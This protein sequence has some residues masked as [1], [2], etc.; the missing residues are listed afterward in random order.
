M[1]RAMLV[2]TMDFLQLFKRRTAEIN[3]KDALWEALVELFTSEETFIAEG[4]GNGVLALVFICE[5][6]GPE[7]PSEWL[8]FAFMPSDW[9][10]LFKG[11]F[12]VPDEPWKDD[13]VYSVWRARALERHREILAQYPLLSRIT[14]IYDDAEYASN[15]V[16]GLIAECKR[17][18][19]RDLYAMRAVAKICL[20][21]EKAQDR[22]FGLLFSAD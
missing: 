11:F 20:A 2:Y 12:C 15:E 21:A 10:A 6:S 4:S 13:D 8:P 22:G 1:A 9:T 17:I 18:T 5:E 14:G 3:D 16:S 19:T 7:G